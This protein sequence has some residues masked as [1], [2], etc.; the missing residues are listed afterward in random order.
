[1][2][3]SSVL[4]SHS[5]FRDRFHCSEGRFNLRQ[6]LFGKI[7]NEF[8]FIGAENLSIFAGIQI[9]MQRVRRVGNVQ[10]RISCLRYFQRFKRAMADGKIGK[11][12]VEMLSRRVWRSVLDDRLQY[13][14]E[15]SEL[16]TYI[17][18]CCS[19]YKKRLCTLFSKQVLSLCSALISCSN[20]LSH[21]GGIRFTLLPS[22]APVSLMLR[23]KRDSERDAGEGGLCPRG[24][25]TLSHAEP[26]C[27]SKTVNSR[28]GHATSLVTDRRIVVE[29]A[30]DALQLPF[31]R[32]T[33]LYCR[34]FPL[35]DLQWR[36]TPSCTSPAGGCL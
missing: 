16:R 30:T 26:F 2:K 32:R 5:T 29:V 25:L 10:Q 11:R 35:A 13:R 7:T 33:V 20:P 23:Y 27:S 17:N 24:P 21:Q 12:E 34:C 4:R 14:C 15:V 1:M 8:M 28:I 31:H 22:R 6:G 18:C 19:G 3:R 36:T 9:V